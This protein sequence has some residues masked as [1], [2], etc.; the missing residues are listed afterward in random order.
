MAARAE[1]KKRVWLRV[2]LNLVAVAIIVAACIEGT[3]LWASYQRISPIAEQIQQDADTVDAAVEDGDVSTLLTSLASIDSNVRS[4]QAELARPEWDVAAGV[5]VLG[6]DVTGARQIVDVAM[7]VMTGTVMPVHNA[8]WQTSELMRTTLDTTLLQVLA[9][10]LG[11]GQANGSSVEQMV[12]MLGTVD[13]AL[14]ALDGSHTDIEA[15]KQILDSLDGKLHFD[16][17]VKARDKLSSTV[18]DLEELLEQAQPLLDG[19]QG[20]K[21]TASEVADATQQAADAVGSAVGD[22]ISSVTGA[23]E[24]DE[25]NSQEGSAVQDGQA[26]AQDGTDSQDGSGSQVSQDSSQGGLLS[27]AKSDIE[28]AAAKVGGDIA[29]FNA[30]AKSAI[31]SFNQ[32]IASLFQG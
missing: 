32:G 29:Q 20:A 22:A 17:L 4:L 8:V 5:P 3:L 28:A 9:S 11:G 14:T 25:A 26:D 23:G 10:L 21:Q 7:D 12:N 15:D 16:A 31:D 1:K 6:Q 24:A 30:D 2:L 19:Y 27:K 18:D 13:G